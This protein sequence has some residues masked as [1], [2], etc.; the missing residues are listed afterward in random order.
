MKPSERYPAMTKWEILFALIVL[1]VAGV[2]ALG[3]TNCTYIQTP[4]E[5]LSTVER[6]MEIPEMIDLLFWDS[7]QHNFDDFLPKEATINFDKLTGHWVLV[8]NR[9]WWD[10]APYY[11]RL[12]ALGHEVCHAAYDHDMLIPDLWYSLDSQA[13][14]YREARAGRCASEIVRKIQG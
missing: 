14:A 13:L 8:V 10:E 4:E 9:Q 1:V 12:N 5:Y 7:D 6:E 3:L 11:T 2:A